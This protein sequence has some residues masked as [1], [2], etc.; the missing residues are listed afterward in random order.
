MN[1]SVAGTAGAGVYVRN[2][3]TCGATLT[4]GI[5]ATCTI[6]LEYRP[7]AAS[8]PVVHNDSYTLSYNN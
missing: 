6:I 4:G 8:A 1:F 5:S 2:G 3:G 7:P